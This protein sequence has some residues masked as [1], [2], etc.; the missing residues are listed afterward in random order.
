MDR[1]TLCRG[2]EKLPG[3]GL[4]WSVGACLPGPSDHDAIPQQSPS[5]VR[6][7]ASSPSR[8]LRVMALAVA[9]GI[10]GTGFDSRPFLLLPLGSSGL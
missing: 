1:A 4:I 6:S 9:V 3:I 5:L 7:R 8:V 2:R 10:T